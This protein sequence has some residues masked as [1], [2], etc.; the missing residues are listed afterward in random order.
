MK[1]QIDMSVAVLSNAPTVGRDGDEVAP[2]HGGLQA[3]SLSIFDAVAA[4]I[5][6]YVDQLI[7]FGIVGIFYNIFE[8]GKVQDETN[9]D[10]IISELNPYFMPGKPIT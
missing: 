6:R 9:F 7:N 1:V 4:R 8:T 5:T 2:A 10:L 3:V